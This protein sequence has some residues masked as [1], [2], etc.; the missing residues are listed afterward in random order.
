MVVPSDAM[1][2]S[3][4]GKFRYSVNNGCDKTASSKVSSHKNT[5]PL[6]LVAKLFNFNCPSVPISSAKRLQPPVAPRVHTRISLEEFPPN[7]GLSAHN[8]VFIPC[9][10]LINA[11]DTPAGPPPIT[12]ISNIITL[13]L[14]LWI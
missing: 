11:A 6:G 2:T 5:F 8:T 12:A 9:L 1:Y 13:F 10:A 7:T 4:M 3:V 14:R